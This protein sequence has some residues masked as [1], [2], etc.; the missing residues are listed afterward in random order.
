MGANLVSE[1]G[2]FLGWGPG[3]Y[4]QPKLRFIEDIIG[5]GYDAAANPPPLSDQAAAHLWDRPR[6]EE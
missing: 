2:H 5:R 4:P 3:P 6:H 1:V